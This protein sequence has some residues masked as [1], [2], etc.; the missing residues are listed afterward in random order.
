[1]DQ[2]LSFD[3]HEQRPGVLIV[4]LCLGGRDVH[5]ELVEVI[6]D[7]STNLFVC[8][9]P[10]PEIRRRPAGDARHGSEGRRAKVLVFGHQKARPGPEVCKEPVELL[11]QLVVRWDL[12]VGLLD[13]LHNVDDL[14]QDSIE[15]GD[16]IVRRRCVGGGRT[17]PLFTMTMTYR[18]WIRRR[19]VRHRSY[20]L[21]WD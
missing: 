16:R 19:R 6:E 12:S 1:M 20:V 4:L 21:S 2:K 3:A 15:C 8:G 18:S 9:V 5:R 7:G 10:R 14:T 13:V 17:S 11:M